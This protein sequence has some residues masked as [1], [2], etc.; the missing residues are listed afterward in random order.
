MRLQLVLTMAAALVAGCA[1]PT[2]T[3]PVSAYATDIALDAHELAGLVRAR[4][5]LGDDFAYAVASNGHWAYTG[6]VD[7]HSVRTALSICQDF[8]LAPCRVYRAGDG[9]NQER[10]RQFATASGAALRA[11]PDVPDKSYHEEAADWDVAAP[12]LVPVRPDS[13]EG[14][15]PLVLPGVRTIRTAGLVRL[16]QTA[17]PLVIDA[18]FYA[19]NLETLPGAL[20]I[21]WIGTPRMSEPEEQALAA[22]LSTVMQWVAPDKER[23]LVVACESSKCWLSVC[24][25]LR[26]R[27]LGYRNLLW[28]RGGK[29]AW[30]EAGLP[31]VAAVPYATLWDYDVHWPIHAAH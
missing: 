8:A 20:V 26:L 31:L 10:Y 24:A 23:P 25:A 16:M 28:Y 15:T 19:L 4:R 13:M 5:D 29:F 1:A 22:R 30:K 6:G 27:A 9:F 3:A 18:E 7:V 11:L 12:A 21:D 14:A 17:R 2:L